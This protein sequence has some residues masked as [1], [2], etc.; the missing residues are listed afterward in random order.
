MWEGILA[1]SA[2]AVNVIIT[3]VAVV[4]LEELTELPDMIRSAVRG[5]TARKSLA[6][7]V[8]DLE[9]RLAAAERKSGRPAA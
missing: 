7:R 1:M 2:L 3:V 9:A 4:A 8:A 6:V 5:R